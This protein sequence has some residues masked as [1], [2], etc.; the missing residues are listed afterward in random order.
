MRPHVD[1][2]IGLRRPFVR[3][4][5]T[6]ERLHRGMDSLV[7][8]HCTRRL[9]RFVARIAGEWTLIGVGPGKD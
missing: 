3:T 8:G 4:Q 6:L 1:P 5:F 7:T 9:E 2:Q